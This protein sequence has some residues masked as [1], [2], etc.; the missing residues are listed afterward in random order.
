MLTKWER[1]KQD[2]ALSMISRLIPQQHVFDPVV[3]VIRIGQCQPKIPQV[4]PEVRLANLMRQWPRAVL[5]FVRQYVHFQLEIFHFVPDFV[6]NL[7]VAD[8]GLRFRFEIYYAQQYGAN[9]HAGEYLQTSSSLLME[10][11]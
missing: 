10:R 2:P 4:L 1:G 8:G 9:K 7:F 6:E 3:A 5:H 11:Y